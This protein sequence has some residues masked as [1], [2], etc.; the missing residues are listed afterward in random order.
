[1]SSVIEKYRFQIFWGGISYNLESEGTLM[2]TNVE[3]R[4]LAEEVL[5]QEL[6]KSNQQIAKPSLFGYCI[7][8]Q[9]K[10][11]DTSYIPIIFRPMTTFAS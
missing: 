11:N 4:K 7:I 10:Q 9:E 6:K 1:M 5:F 3:L 2:L 8:R